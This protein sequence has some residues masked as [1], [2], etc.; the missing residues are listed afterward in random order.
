[1]YAGA[2]DSSGVRLWYTSTPRE[3]DAGALVV[4]HFV[5]PQ[6]IIPPNVQNFT[7]TAIVPEDCTRAVSYMH[8]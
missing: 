1:M 7:T 3:H 6:Q 4:G 2:V 5:S 8:V